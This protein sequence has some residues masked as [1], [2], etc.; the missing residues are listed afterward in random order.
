MPVKKTTHKAPSKK[1]VDEAAASVEKA[2]EQLEVEEIEV[3]T[4]STTISP[5]SKE[6]GGSEVEQETTAKENN[7]G[8][9]EKQE[10]EKKD[11]DIVN[12]GSVF[13]RTSFEKDADKKGSKVSKII[14][15]ICLCII[16]T[17]LGFTGGYFYG[18]GYLGVNQAPEAVE[19]VPTFTPTPTVEEVDLSAY[20]IEILNGSGVAGVAGSEQGALEADGFN[21]ENTGNA[22]TQD[23]TETAIAVKSSV[24][25][26]FMEKLKTSLSERYVV[27]STVGELEDDNE[28]DV[29]VTIGSETVV[30][31]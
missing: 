15:I 5:G 31:E 9:E 18:K 4:E 2:I 7:S 16:F 29:V 11:N 19:T 12:T 30:D 6:E 23:F 26:A 20:S 8:E 21:V 1:E 13:T 22:A 27:D 14:I 10:E 3:K 17:I 25:E 28:Y 24:S